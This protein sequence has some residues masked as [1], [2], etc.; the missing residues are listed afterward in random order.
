MS[1][2]VLH[3]EVRHSDGYVERHDHEWSMSARDAFRHRL[4][5]L[6]EGRTPV[7]ADWETLTITCGNEILRF[8]DVS[9]S[10]AEATLFEMEATA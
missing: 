1:P 4:Q 10:D 6:R 3:V 7:G 5:G 8:E 2:C 9:E